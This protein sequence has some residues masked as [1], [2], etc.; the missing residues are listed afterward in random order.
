MKALRKFLLGT[1]AGVAGLLALT[2]TS[3][4][5]YVPAL[6]GVS[7]LGGGNY[8]WTYVVALAPAENARPG[9]NPTASSTYNA[10]TGT[11]SLTA[12]DY[13]SF[14]TFYDV[15]A[16]A[17]VSNV[18]V[19]GPY[20]IDSAALGV[21]PSNVNPIPPDSATST[22]YTFYYTGASTLLGPE[23]I[24]VGFDTNTNLF[25]LGAYSSDAENGLLTLTND[26]NG[27]A[28]ILPNTQ[29]QVVTPLPASAFGGM[30]LL[31]LLGI[32]RFVKARRQLA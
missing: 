22:N 27:G 9:L 24:F 8:H 19:T 25:G 2:G 1:A 14:F 6:I 17:T 7:S 11:V 21:T 20:A 32:G 31:G 26:G 15:N 4:A 30:A 16:N 18:T 12:T 23:T 5:D 13:A 10:A 28:L 3:R 29:G